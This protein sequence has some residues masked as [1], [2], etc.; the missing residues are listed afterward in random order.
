M[1][2]V[3]ITKSITNRDSKALEYYLKDI[4]K[5]DQIGV[6]EEAELTQLI[7]NGDE[8]ALSRLITANLRFVVSVAKQYQN[9]G[10]SLS[11][12]IN[13]GNLGLIKAANRFDETRGFKFISYA[14]WWI[15]QA[16]LHSLA[17]HSRMIRMPINRVGD[18]SKIYKVFSQLEQEYERE[19]TIYEMSELLDLKP[20]DISR[21]I[22]VSAKHKSIDAPL[23]D[24]EN[25]SLKEVIEDPASDQFERKLLMYESLS[26]ELKDLLRCLNDRQQLIVQLYF[27][28]GE[29]Y[30]WSLEDIGLKIGLTRERVRQIKDKAVLKLR[31][32]SKTGRLRTFFE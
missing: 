15:R 29:K 10:L 23:L 12:L 7:K 8:N 5:I 17:E 11:D 27:G 26:I 19:P 24:G 14:V 25:S 13:E 20:T 18:V 28:I 6:D 4:N 21:I 22:A 30:A 1:R 31:A 32:S 9:Q 16:I 2:Q 3:R